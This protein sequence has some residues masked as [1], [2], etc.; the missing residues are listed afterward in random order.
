MPWGVL[1]VVADSIDCLSSGYLVSVFAVLP[2]ARISKAVNL[3][4]GALQTGCRCCGRGLV[5]FNP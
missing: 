2:V 4:M 3:S 5:F 1:E